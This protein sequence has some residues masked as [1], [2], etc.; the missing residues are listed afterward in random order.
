MTSLLRGALT[1]AT[2]AIGAAGLSGCVVTPVDGGPAYVAPAPAYVAP[3]PV[4]V[5]PRDYYGRPYYYGRP[6][7]GGMH[8]WH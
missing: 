7:Y 2:L 4:S 6:H 1:A 3:A 5:G 8:R